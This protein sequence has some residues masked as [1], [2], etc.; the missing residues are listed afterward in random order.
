MSYQY[1]S[2]DELRCQHTGKLGMNDDFMVKMVA[3]REE[4]GKPM[5]VTSAF[6]D[7]THPTEAKKDKPGAHAS[8]RAIDIHVAGADVIE[9]LMIAKQHGIT[10][11]GIQQKGPQL[12]RFV[13]LDD[14]TEDD[15][16]PITMWS[17]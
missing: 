5:Y 17:Y 16:F 10:R 13:H 6:R 11:F 9:L 3:I 12:S 14:L 1:F 15:G 4:W 7:P 8:G 2:D